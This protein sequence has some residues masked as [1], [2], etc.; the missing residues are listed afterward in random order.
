[1]DRECEVRDLEM[2]ERHIVEGEQRIT[3]QVALLEGLREKRRDVT[4]AERLLDLLE[5]TLAQWHSHRMLI[6]ERI[7]TIDA[8]NEL[9]CEVSDARA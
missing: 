8:S 3:T 9:A 1:M 5:D 2:A 6:R 7:A 4:A